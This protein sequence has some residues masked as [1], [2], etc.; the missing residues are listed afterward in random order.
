MSATVPISVPELNEVQA[1]AK[2][3]HTEG[4]AWKGE[5]FG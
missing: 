3:R 1:F 2:K 5:A 4:K